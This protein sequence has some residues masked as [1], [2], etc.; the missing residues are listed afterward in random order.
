MLNAQGVQQLEGKDHTC[1]EDCC[2][3]GSLE[4][5]AELAAQA[6]STQTRKP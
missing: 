4:G 3:T 1:L 2:D 6:T 5:E